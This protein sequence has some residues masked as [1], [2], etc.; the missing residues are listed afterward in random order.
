MPRAPLPTNETQRLATLERYEILDTPPEQSYDDIALLASRICDTPIAAVS[1]VDDER[2]WFKSRVGLEAHETP[3]DIAFCAHAIL[4]PREIL[5]V[6]DATLDPRFADN[7]LVL[8]APRSRFYAGAPLVAPGELPL[9]PLCVIDQ[10]PRKLTDEQRE[11]LAA[12][13]R[14]VVSELELRLHVRQL[15]EQTKRLRAAHTELEATRRA[16]IE[17]KDQLLRHV[18]HELRTPLA[19]LHQFLSLLIDDIGEPDERRQF[20]ELAFKSA[21]QLTG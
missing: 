15:Q 5:E 16:Q 21:T 7:P 13:A 14:R 19:A 9:G 10:Q 3:R 11:S 12:L 1:L 18:S 20:L 8:K 4:K 2:Q 17:V 6:T